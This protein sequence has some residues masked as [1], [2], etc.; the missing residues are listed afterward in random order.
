MSICSIRPQSLYLDAAPAGAVALGD[1]SVVGRTYLGEYWNY[2]VRPSGGG[3]SLKV[4]AAPSTVLEIGQR[5]TI[6]VDPG[7]VAAIQ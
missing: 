4:H 3:A 2:L 5:S 6:Y 1:V 7:A